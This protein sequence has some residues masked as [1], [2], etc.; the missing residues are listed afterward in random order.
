MLYQAVERIQRMRL[1]ML[2]INWSKSACTFVFLWASIS[3]IGTSSFGQDNGGGG[4][5]LGGNGGNSGGAGNNGNA[6]GAAQADFDTLI[7]LITATIA[8]DSW[9][10]VGGTGTLQGFPVGS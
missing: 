9:E 7:E 1:N 8:P 5:F 4:A 2:T 10:D 3:F 6:G